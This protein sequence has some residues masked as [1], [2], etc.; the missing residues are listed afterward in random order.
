MPWHPVGCGVPE[1]VGFL[2]GLLSGFLLRGGVYN[3]DPTKKSSLGGLEMR[4]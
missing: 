2:K 3:K 1:V 4:V